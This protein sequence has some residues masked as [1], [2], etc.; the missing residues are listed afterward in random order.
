[1]K[2]RAR[3]K[4]LVTYRCPSGYVIRKT[5]NQN[6]HRSNNLWVVAE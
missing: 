2:V 1:M 5:T 6:R 4:W 3:I